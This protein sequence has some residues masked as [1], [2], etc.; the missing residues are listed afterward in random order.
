MRTLT[1]SCLLLC[2]L[3]LLGCDGTVS[4][5]FSAGDSFQLGAAELGVPATYQ[6]MDQTVPSYSCATVACPDVGVPVSC[7]A[8]V[9]D[10]EPIV[11]DTPVGGV[12]DMDMYIANL[13]TPYSQINS[14]E[15]LDAKY[16]IV[17]NT[18]TFGTSPVAIHWAPAGAVSADP[19]MGAQLLGTVPAIAAM[20]SGMG[21]VDLD[22]G[23]NAALSDYL[24]NVQGQIKLFATMEVDLAPGDPFPA[25]GMTV[26]VVLT[27]RVTGQLV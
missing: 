14:I 11:I 2:G 1:S 10:P 26:E 22:A 23:G 25:G 4:A 24:S 9:C 16:N 15:I 21:Q 13:D 7:V 5:T 20:Q 27:V 8:D 18:V 12:I 17:D 19:A 6:T 3:A